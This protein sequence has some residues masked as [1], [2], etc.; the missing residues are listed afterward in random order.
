MKISAYFYSDANRKQ[1]EQ[2]C[3]SIFEEHGGEHMWSDTLITGQPPDTWERN[4]TYNVPRASVKRVKAALEKE[5][6]RL[7]SAPIF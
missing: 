5:G 3:N 7:V 2:K 1:K 4:V 6:F